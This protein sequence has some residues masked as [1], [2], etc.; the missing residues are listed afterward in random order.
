MGYHVQSGARRRSVDV[1]SRDGEVTPV[2]AVEGNI[3]TSL[4]ADAGTPYN[5]RQGHQAPLNDSSTLERYRS[6]A[7][8]GHDGSRPDQV[9]VS[10]AKTGSN[11][12]QT[13]KEEAPDDS[14]IGNF[15]GVGTSPLLQDNCSCNTPGGRT[16]ASD[17]SQSNVIFSSRQANGFETHASPQVRSPTTKGTSMMP[18]T[19][20]HAA[21]PD[22]TRHVDLGAITLGTPDALDLTSAKPNSE[23]CE[24]ADR[25]TTASQSAN[26]RSRPLF[27]LERLGDLNS[28]P[29]VCSR[30]QPIHG[31]GS[32]AV[33][34]PTPKEVS[35]PAVET[36]Q[37]KGDLPSSPQDKLSPQLPQPEAQVPLSGGKTVAV[38]AELFDKSPSGPPSGNVLR[39]MISLT[40][41][42]IPPC[43]ITLDDDD[44]NDG[45][46]IVSPAESP[47]A[48]FDPND[49]ILVADQNAVPFQL[50]PFQNANSLAA[51]PLRQRSMSEQSDQLTNP[52]EDGRLSPRPSRLPWVKQPPSYESEI[53]QLRQE[54]SVLALQA[55]QREKE[56]VEQLRYSQAR[57]AELGGQRNVAK[58]QLVDA[59]NKIN[60]LESQLVETASSLHALQQMDVSNKM[61]LA[62]SEQRSEIT[63]RELNQGQKKMQE[64]LQHLS[65]RDEEIKKLKSEVSCKWAWPRPADAIKAARGEK[66][67]RGGR[68]ASDLGPAPGDR[69]ARERPAGSDRGNSPAK[70]GKLRLF[71]SHC[72]RLKVSL[73]ANELQKLVHQSLAE[74]TAKILSAVE[75]RKGTEG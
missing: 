27:N 42:E 68:A 75:N 58:S 40:P 30:P 2:K 49:T 32:G 59:R 66:S 25:D 16:S 29:L 45:D 74:S 10:I 43:V 73:Q 51:P 70:P 26:S 13:S 28:S 38:A 46:S 12:P 22:A 36:A 71:G 21:D 50:S 15:S 53:Y 19:A 35:S 57:E 11:K 7:A 41:Q 37:V 20:S 39:R 14:A 8:D 6:E 60:W 52:S 67:S 62:A 34:S 31:Q 24:Q 17:L 55:D 1:P 65:E 4:K 18:Q 54:L 64:L 5:V 9:R 63:R 48:S 61:R 72:G 44:D 33:R 47:S 56:L 69:R 23:D 3:W